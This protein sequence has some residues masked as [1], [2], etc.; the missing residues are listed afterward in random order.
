[1]LPTRN[2]CA[3]LSIRAHFVALWSHRGTAYVTLN[4]H[5]L[6]IIYCHENPQ[7]Q[8]CYCDNPSR[9][10]KIGM[11]KVFR[12]RLAGCARFAIPWHG[13]VGSSCGQPGHL[14]SEPKKCGFKV[15]EAIETVVCSVIGHRPG[16]RPTHCSRS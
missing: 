14:A 11:A 7:L 8:G 15:P 16:L 3:R 13:V 10:A 12:E 1:M 5:G 6:R 9:G 4:Y 2:I